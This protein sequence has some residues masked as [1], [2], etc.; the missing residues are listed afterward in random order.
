MALTRAGRTS[1][2]T[3]PGRWE[4]SRACAGSR[5]RAR[6]L[7]AAVRPK[8]TLAAASARSRC[9]TPPAFRSARARA[10][11]RSSRRSAC[12]S[13]RRSVPGAAASDPGAAVSC[14]ASGSSSATVRASR[15]ASAAG[16]TTRWLSAIRQPD[17]A[18]KSPD[19]AAQRIVL[20]WRSSGDSPMA[21]SIERSS[22]AT[23]PIR[24]RRSAG[25]SGS[26]SHGFN[27]SSLKWNRISRPN[28]SM[29][30]ASLRG[31][32]PRSDRPVTI[33]A[34][35]MPIMISLARLIAR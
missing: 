3:R 17:R 14:Q 5:S 15:R 7:A 27:R 35:A 18:A 21:W 30:A 13:D 16:I 29:V 2:T 26:R 22:A 25:P 11:A 9:D 31:D 19:M 10:A 12:R 28:R 1:A 8:A 23:R 4:G 34:Q 32:W 20:R 6:P 33:V 24:S